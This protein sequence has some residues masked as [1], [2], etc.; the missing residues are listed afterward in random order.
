MDYG[1]IGQIAKA[2]RYAEER[3]RVRFHAFKVSLAG[4]NHM[5]IIT[6]SETSGWHCT[7]DF[8]RAH[9]WSSHT[10]AL[11]RI[12]QG[13][14]APTPPTESKELG[15]QSAIISQIEKA[16]KYASE[17]KRVRFHSFTAS[18][19]GD[20]H[21][22]TVRYEEGKWECTCNFYKS[23]GWCSHIIA[24]ERILGVM[25]APAERAAEPR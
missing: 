24:M 12:L 18:F 8:F 1:I 17:P 19:S 15:A 6:Y 5:H 11:E 4:D 10:I 22:H 20:N 3:H 13:M 7:S 21:T 2:R 23:H 25:V 14:I 16:K 9:G